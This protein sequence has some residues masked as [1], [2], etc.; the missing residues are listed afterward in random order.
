MLD[1]KLITD[2]DAYQSGI[3]EPVVMLSSLRAAIWDEDS[4]AIAMAIDEISCERW[5]VILTAWMIIGHMQGEGYEAAEVAALALR[6]A[7]E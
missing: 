1:A 2:I 5:S 4:A 7:T 3:I 6:V